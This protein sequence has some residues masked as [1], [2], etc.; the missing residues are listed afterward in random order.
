MEILEN[1]NIRKWKM[2]KLENEYKIVIKNID[3]YKWI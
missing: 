3:G 2:E 1:G